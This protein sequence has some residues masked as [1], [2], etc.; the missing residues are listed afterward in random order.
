[1]PTINFACL[2]LC[3]MI[4]MVASIATDPPK[5]QTSNNV[6]S[7]IRRAPRRAA[8]LSYKVSKAAKALTAV[9]QMP[10]NSRALSASIKGLRVAVTR[11]DHGLVDHI[12][13]LLGGLLQLFAGRPADGFNDDMRHGG[14]L[15]YTLYGRLF[16]LSCFHH[17][18]TLRFAWQREQNK[19]LDDTLHHAACFNFVC[20]GKAFYALRIESI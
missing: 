3:R 6:R 1:M 4:R 14:F 5:T 19:Q 10:R 8:R 16:R 13:N 11:F 20:L 7:R 17:F 2:V 9:S 15:L 12:G 18:I